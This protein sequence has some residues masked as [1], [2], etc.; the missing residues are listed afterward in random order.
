MN[1]EKL[2]KYEKNIT[3]Q[4]GED[5]IIEYLVK[6]S[7]TKI[8]KSCLEVGAGDGKTCSNTHVLWNEQDW[9]AI[10]VE[11]DEKN[12][13]LYKNSDSSLASY[14]KL[15]NVTVINKRLEIE[16]EA[17]IDNIVLST[18]SGEM[19]NLGVLS[20]DIDSI[21]Y[22]IFEGVKKIKPQI[23]VIEFNNHIPPNIDYFDPVDELFLRCS[24]KALERLGREKGYKLVAC[25]VTNAFLLR[26]DCFD[27]HKHPNM[28]VE[29]LFD[30]EGQLKNGSAPFIHIGS[31]RVTRFPVF[32]K[33][34]TTFKRLYWRLRS[35]VASLRPGDMKYIQPSEKI[36]KRLRDSDIFI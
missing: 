8:N 24:A 27:A 17:S 12:Y 11:C 23:V 5:G 21:D 19:V 33:E 34:P 7:A 9:Q 14:E 26:E 2:N 36:V 3:S 16:G 1:N 20:I 30:Y 18:L 35:F 6:T 31:Q 13:N 15:D 10:L 25:T 32:S 29:Y 28:P 22:H 4:Y